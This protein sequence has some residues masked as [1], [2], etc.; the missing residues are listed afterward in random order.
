MRDV[1]VTINSTDTAPDILNALLNQ[2]GLTYDTMKYTSSGSAKNE[3]T[4]I[5]IKDVHWLRNGVTGSAFTPHYGKCAE[6]EEAC[7]E[8][9]DGTPV[10]CEE[11]TETAGNRLRAGILTSSR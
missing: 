8:S 7:E 4:D 10:L 2:L 3:P 9:I 6:C 1:V 11:C 5:T